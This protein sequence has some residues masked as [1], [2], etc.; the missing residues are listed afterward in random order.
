MALIDSLHKVN[1]W[2][3][4]GTGN[5]GYRYPVKRPEFSSLLASMDRTRIQILVGPRRVGKSTLLHQAISH[6]LETG[7]HPNRILFFSGDDPALQL[8]SQDLGTILEV[9]SVE[10]LGE[11]FGESQEKVYIFIDEIHFLPNWQKWIKSYYDRRLGIRFL[12]SG[13]SATHLFQG[14]NESLL[15][16]VDTLEVLPLTASRFA[17]F[18]GVCRKDA[19]IGEFETLLPEFSVFEKPEAYFEAVRK[20]MYRLSSFQP[21]VTAMLREHLLA[22][23][24][25]EYFEADSMA[26][27]HRRLA[28]DIV[29][30]G[31]YRDIVSNHR[32]KSP[33]LLEKLLYCIAANNGQAFAFTTLAQTLGVDTETVSSYLGFLQVA[34]LVSIQENHST[35]VMKTIRKNK[36]L[37]IVDN[38]ICNALIRHDELNSTREGSLVEASCVQT[39]RT[40]AEERFY[41]MEY[42]RDGDSEVDIVL[43]RK[44]DLLP[45]EVKYR[46]DPT[47][48]AGLKVFM[49]RFGSTVGLVVTKDLLEKEDG[50]VFCPY[51]LMR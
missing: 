28:E 45:I 27:W 51:W 33:E 1:P 4:T 24:Y 19:R 14:S 3:R 12:L 2:W 10:V 42:W 50:I 29:T 30:Q 6:L 25:P 40:L 35:N 23:G 48:I 11:A 16:R 36:K 17:H 13:S 44:T 32:I 5:P 46:N 47:D 41:R 37:Y 22:G 39:V 9:Y 49:K 43:D 26:G 18:Y 7:T 20:E 38:G 15:G 34:F 21:S 8:H 31:L